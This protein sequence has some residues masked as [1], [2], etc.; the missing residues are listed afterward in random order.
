MHEND[1]A[2]DQV[3]QFD[4]NCDSPGSSNNDVHI[5]RKLQTI[6]YINNILIDNRGD[7]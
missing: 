6:T 1:A 5:E 2:I 3:S 7:Y 4:E